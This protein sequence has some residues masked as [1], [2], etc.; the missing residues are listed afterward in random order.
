VNR[1]II[2]I[3]S[4]VAVRVDVLLQQHPF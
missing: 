1:R 4:C 2:A 3:A